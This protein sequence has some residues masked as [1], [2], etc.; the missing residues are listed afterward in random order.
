MPNKSCALWSIWIELPLLHKVFFFL[1]FVVGAYSLFSATKVLARVRSLMTSGHSK[2]E[3]SLQNQVA[4][5]S[6]QSANTR[7]LITASF[8]LFG[9][10]FFL[11]YAFHVVDSRQQDSG[12]NT[13]FGEFLLVFCFCCQRILRVFHSAFSAVAYLRSFASMRTVSDHFAYRVAKSPAQCQ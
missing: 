4:A 1:L 10:V 13:H 11:G 5:L 6:A 8:Y 2:D 7:H 12:L 3:I 9:I